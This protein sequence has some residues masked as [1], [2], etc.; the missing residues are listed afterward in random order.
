MAYEN[1]SAHNND[2]SSTRN[3]WNQRYE[4]LC[5]FTRSRLIELCNIDIQEITDNQSLQAWHQS[6]DSES[7]DAAEILGHLTI[8]RSIT[9]PGGGDITT[10]ND[11]LQTIG[12][13]NMNLVRPVH[14]NEKVTEQQA[15]GGHNAYIERSTHM[16]VDEVEGVSGQ[17]CNKLPSA[18]GENRMQAE[19]DLNMDEERSMSLGE[20]ET[21]D[22]MHGLFREVGEDAWTATQMAP[23]VEVESESSCAA[24]VDGTRTP[25]SNVVLKRKRETSMGSTFLEVVLHSVHRYSSNV[26]TEP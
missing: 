8:L 1:I 24:Q 22:G 7:P 4:E 19:G 17:E 18:I 15:L 2:E 6:V 26:L 5:K 20:N 11:T 9:W 16:H 21:T 10:L 3:I 25:G 23:N 14:R 12:R 13:A